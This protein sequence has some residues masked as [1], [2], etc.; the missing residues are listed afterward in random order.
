MLLLL[1]FG[2]TDLN[3]QSGKSK[4]QTKIDGYR[5]QSRDFG[6]AFFRDELKGKEGCNPDITIE[7]EGKDRNPHEQKFKDANDKYL[8][9]N[10]GNG[11]LTSYSAQWDKDY[12]L[13]LIGREYCRDR[14][15]AV[16][17]EEFKTFEMW[18]QKK[19]QLIMAHYKWIKSILAQM[20]EIKM[21]LKGYRYLDE[22]IELCTELGLNVQED[23][24]IRCNSTGLVIYNPKNLAERI[25][26][27]KNK[28][29]TREQKIAFRKQYENAQSEVVN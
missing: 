23:E 15:I 26:G 20:K 14:Q 16:S 6:Y 21:G 13:D 18:Q 27:M 24:V 11:N 5:P 9:S 12:E 10:C 22:A 17:R 25:K 2:L 1:I 3:A 28:T 4:V 8:G 19:G 7:M 29:I